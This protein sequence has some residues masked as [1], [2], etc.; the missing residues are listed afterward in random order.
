M[1]RADPAPEGRDGRFVSN[2]NSR[3]DVYADQLAGRRVPNKEQVDRRAQNLLSMWAVWDE[4]RLIQPN[5]D[6]FTIEKRTNRRAAGSLPGQANGHRDWSLQ[7]MY[8]VD[9]GVAIRNFWQSYPASLEV[10]NAGS[11]AAELRAWLWSPDAPAMDLRHY[12]TKAH[13]LEEVYED[14]QPGLSTP[15]GIARTSELMLLPSAGVPSKEETVKMA[16]ASAQPPLL[17]CT[18][19]HMQSVQAFGIWG[20]E[21][22][23][24]PPNRRSRS[25]WRPR[26]TIT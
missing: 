17:V 24:T 16:H 23:T 5:A 15:H 10:R 6:G 26:S 25:G 19:K 8:Q 2:P 1:G 18:P 20:L 3:G 22:R 11:E 12:D 4:F 9:W 13:G 7:A 21:D 14:V